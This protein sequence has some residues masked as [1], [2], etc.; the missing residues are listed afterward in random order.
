[1]NDSVEGKRMTVEIIS[2]SVSTK[3]WD[4]AGIELTTPGS[5][6]RL[7]SGARQDT[8]CTMR[9]GDLQT[10]VILKYTTESP[11]FSWHSLQQEFKQCFQRKTM[12]PK[13]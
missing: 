13:L 2:R 3:V 8:S 6:N 4:Q 5:A 11:D 1:M 12:S 9:P 7:A 10:T